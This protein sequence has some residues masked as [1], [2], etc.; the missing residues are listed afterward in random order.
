MRSTPK[1]SLNVAHP[2][3][4]MMTSYIK[5]AVHSMIVNQVYTWSST[6]LVSPPESSEDAEG[7]VA[8]K[9]CC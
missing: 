5:A 3:H 9:W 8:S 1:I 4:R 7:F 2:I 6:A